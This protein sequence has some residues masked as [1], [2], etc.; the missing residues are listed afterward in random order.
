VTVSCATVA[1]IDGA[2]RKYSQSYKAALEV[3]LSL[4]GSRTL[5]TKQSSLST[6][7]GG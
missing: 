1:T 3:D 6:A 4:P 5:R 7:I 2:E